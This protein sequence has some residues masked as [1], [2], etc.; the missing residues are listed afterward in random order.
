MFPALAFRVDCD[1][2]SVAFSGDTSPSSNLAQLAQ[3]VDLLVHEAI[4]P[5][6]GQWQF[7][8][9]PH[10]SAQR[11]A[12]DLVEAKHSRADQVG[13]VAEAAGARHLVLTHLVPASAPSDHWETATIGYSG[14]FHHGEDLWTFP[15]GASR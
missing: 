10:T 1:E 13:A 12:I 11:A 7:G 14:T 3:G 9:G 6:Y 15:L 4:S 2:G 8:P 5:A